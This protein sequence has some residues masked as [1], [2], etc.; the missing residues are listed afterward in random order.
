[1][2][3]KFVNGWAVALILG[4]LLMTS[5]ALRTTDVRSSSVPTSS[6]TSSSDQSASS[7]SS[8]SSSSSSSVGSSSV[9]DQK[10]FDA[11][12]YFGSAESGTWD[13]DQNGYWTQGV[14]YGYSKSVDQVPYFMA[15]DAMPSNALAPNPQTYEDA[16]MTYD[17]KWGCHF[18]ESEN[19]IVYVDSFKR[20]TAETFPYQ[21]ATKKSLMY[22]YVRYLDNY[23]PETQR[24]AK[25][26]GEEM[27]K[28]AEDGRSH[29]PSGTHAYSINR[30]DLAS[31]EVQEE[32]S[33]CID[34][35]ISYAT[36][37][38][39]NMA[40]DWTQADAYKQVKISK[41][42]QYFVF[43]RE[44]GWS[45]AGKWVLKDYVQDTIIS[46]VMDAYAALIADVKAS[47]VYQALPDEKKSYDLPNV[48][49]V[50]N[51]ISVRK[52]ELTEAVGRTLPWSY[53]GL[54]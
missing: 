50:D 35:T 24:F 30:I 53:D 20:M 54:I 27:T 6:S 42:A 43:K 46:D 37:K 41:S 44:G 31:K 48:L 13:D 36:R 21:D 22:S 33:S 52:T 34:D 29:Y 9:G 14:R 32:W 11:D 4:T 28:S 19:Y 10:S 18:P 7:T 45:S 16:W 1:M 51:G 40:I 38:S 2:R 26:L 23:I 12:V 3:N 49:L 15:L 8:S 17:G 25:G 47:S 39:N 5:C